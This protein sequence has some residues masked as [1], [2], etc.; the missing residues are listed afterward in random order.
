M[1]KLIPS[2]TT[3][4]INSNKSTEGG[5]NVGFKWGVRKNVLTTSYLTHG[6]LYDV[7]YRYV[8][9]LFRFLSF[10]FTFF[11]PSSSLPP[12]HSGLGATAADHRARI[13]SASV[14]YPK[15]LLFAR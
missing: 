15:G 13:S 11:L 2:T 1:A 6:G 3:E 5:T 12:L 9:F 4:R 14:P 8:L 7:D 10:Q